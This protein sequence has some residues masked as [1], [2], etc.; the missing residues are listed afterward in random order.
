MPHT[1]S[2]SPYLHNRFLGSSEISSHVAIQYGPGHDLPQTDI[3]LPNSIQRQ[4]LCDFRGSPLH[5]KSGRDF[6]SQNYSDFMGSG[7]D[8]SQGHH[9]GFS[10]ARG[11]MGSS[12]ASGTNALGMSYTPPLQRTPSRLSGG[13]MHRHNLSVGSSLSNTSNISLNMGAD[14]ESLGRP[15]HSTPTSHS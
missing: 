13:F 11:T 2:G 10:T 7:I 15:L 3:P 8:A 1:L 6:D 4:P 12:S 14:E 5:Y 9:T